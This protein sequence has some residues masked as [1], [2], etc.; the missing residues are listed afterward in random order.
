MERSPNRDFL[1]VLESE[2]KYLQLYEEYNDEFHRLD[3]QKLVT[4]WNHGKKTWLKIKMGSP[5]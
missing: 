1:T 2:E 5:T 4:I 3:D